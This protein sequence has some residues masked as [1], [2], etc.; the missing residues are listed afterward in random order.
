MSNELGAGM[1]KAAQIAAHTSMGMGLVLMCCL[2]TLL[3][4]FRHPL[5]HLVTSDPEV[6]AATA[7][8]LP[9]SSL[10]TVGDGMNAVLS[11]EPRC[12]QPA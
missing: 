1:P 6:V 12:P 2:A 3:A 8:V 5:A 4:A 7:A 10:M 9:I 11:G